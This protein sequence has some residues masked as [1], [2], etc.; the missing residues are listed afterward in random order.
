[1]QFAYIIDSNQ[2]ICQ[3]ILMNEYLLNADEFNLNLAKKGFSSV[4][5]FANQMGIH[6]NTINNYLYG[7]SSVFTDAFLKICTGLDANPLNLISPTNTEFQQ[8]QKLIT[9]IKPLLISYPNLALLLIGSRARGNYKR[10]SDWDLGITSGI[11]GTDT[12][13]YLRIKS[14]VEDLAEDLPVI[15]DLVNLDRAP[16]WF[17]AEFDYKPKFIC[18]NITSYHH[19]LGILDGIN[20]AKTDR[21]GD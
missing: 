9:A 16:Y 15:V 8:I 20:K 11:H 3:I 18:G 5:T 1:M 21:T 14:T 10:R 19:L 13:T 12:S 2:V 4:S 6:R 7:K 17:L